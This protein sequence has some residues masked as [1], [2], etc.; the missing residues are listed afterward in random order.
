MQKSSQI[1]G[2]TAIRIMTFFFPLIK[3]YLKIRDLFIEMLRQAMY[4][5]YKTHF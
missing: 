3:S 5:K 4:K 1:P 2:D